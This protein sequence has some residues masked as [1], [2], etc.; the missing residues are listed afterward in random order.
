MNV[1]QT[2]RITK[3]IILGIWKLNQFHPI[4]IPDQIVVMNRSSFNFLGLVQNYSVVS[5]IWDLS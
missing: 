1:V 3:N 2:A 5:E 4:L